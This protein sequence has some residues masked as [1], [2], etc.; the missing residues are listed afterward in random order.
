MKT[1]PKWPL[2]TELKLWLQLTII[3][4]TGVCP[5]FFYLFGYE[6]SENSKAATNNFL[7][8]SMNCLI[9]KMFLKKWK[10]AVYN[11]SIPM[12]MSLI[13]LFCLK[14][15]NLLSYTRKNSNQSSYVSSWNQSMF[16]QTM[17]N[18]KML[19]SIIKKK[20]V[21]SYHCSSKKNSKKII[22]SE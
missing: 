18:S 1:T 2:L 7:N 5:L 3:F 10:Y 21:L 14:V 9:Y 15:F 19:W 20:H 8:S 16:F 13:H 12:A 17:T 6:L 22:I 11:V 4:I